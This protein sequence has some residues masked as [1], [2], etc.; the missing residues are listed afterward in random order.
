MKK[1]IVI[2]LM[3]LLTAPVY[4]QYST[5]SEGNNK[6]IP[7]NLSYRQLRS[8]YNPNSYYPMSD[9]VYN[10]LLLGVASAFVPG[11]GELLAGKAGRAA[12]KVV[13]SVALDISL[14]ASIYIASREINGPNTNGSFYFTGLAMGSAVAISALWA[15]GIGDAIKVAKV[16]NMYLRDVRKQYGID[17]DFTPQVGI[18]PY[19]GHSPMLGMRVALSF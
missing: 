11:L 5:T 3:V 9:D 19:D 2:M 15:W 8:I 18:S 16:K 13:C 7:L 10:P 17:L 4:A 12:V 1:V 14:G 6:N